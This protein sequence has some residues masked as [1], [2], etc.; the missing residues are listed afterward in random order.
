MI[1]KCITCG[2]DC[3]V[4]IDEPAPEKCNNCDEVISK[5]TNQ[6]AEIIDIYDED[7]LENFI[8]SK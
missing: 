8:A 2:S 4:S 3:L 5:L 6:I 7:E 1:R